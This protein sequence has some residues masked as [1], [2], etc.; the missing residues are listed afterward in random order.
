MLHF[1]RHFQILP[2]RFN[3]ERLVDLV[4]LVALALL[5]VAIIAVVFPR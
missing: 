3:G 5:A 4:S 1:R 2:A